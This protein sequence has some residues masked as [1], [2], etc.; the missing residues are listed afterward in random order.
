MNLLALRIPFHTVPAPAMD[1]LAEH[2]V[3]IGLCFPGLMDPEQEPVM[4][5]GVNQH[6]GSGDRSLAPGV[7]P[8][9]SQRRPTQGRWLCR[10]GDHGLVL[11]E[12]RF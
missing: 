5:R 10:V 7:S 11:V 2:H 3:V 4:L 9:P 6:A 12:G 8:D 1:L